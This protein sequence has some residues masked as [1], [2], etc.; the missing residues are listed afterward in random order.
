M[1]L[2]NLSAWV[3]ATFG[4]TMKDF[5]LLAGAIL[6]IFGLLWIGLYSGKPRHREAARFGWFTLI[7]SFAVIAWG[8]YNRTPGS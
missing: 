8:L 6:T 2:Q 5:A 7:I 1:S 3:L 4:I